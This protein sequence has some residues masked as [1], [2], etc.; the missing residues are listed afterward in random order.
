MLAGG[1]CSVDD[2]SCVLPRQPV[3]QPWLSEASTGE[4][5]GARTG[6]TGARTAVRSAD[7]T[8]ACESRFT[9]TRPAPDPIERG[10]ALQAP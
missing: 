10:A 3:P 6:E 2:P 4:A 8:S 5:I 7:V 1:V 9:A